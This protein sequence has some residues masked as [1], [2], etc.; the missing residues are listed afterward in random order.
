MPPQNSHRPTKYP[1]IRYV[2]DEKRR[3]A[4]SLLHKASKQVFVNVIA[5]GDD[6]VTLSVTR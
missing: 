6:L 5:N 2:C 3:I 1:S 4:W